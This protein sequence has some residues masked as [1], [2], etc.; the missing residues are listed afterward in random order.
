MMNPNTRIGVLTI[1]AAYM[2]AMMPLPDWAQAFRPDWVTLVLIYWTMALPDNIGVTVA[3]FAGL[4]LDVTHGALLGQHA[5]GLVLVIYV[6]H[7]QHQ[8]LRVAS[9]LQQALVILFLLLIKQ[10]LVL[11]VSG[12]MGHAPDS[13]LYFM[14]SVTS[15]IFWPWVYIILRD[16]RRKFAYKTHF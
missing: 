14:P 9:L 4:M 13:W 1:I 5:L 2:L 6:I 12:I 11:W 8:R 10:A 3:W 15:A 16:L 7:A